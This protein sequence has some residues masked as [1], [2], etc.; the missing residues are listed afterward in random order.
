MSSSETRPSPNERAGVDVFVLN[1]G[2][3]FAWAFVT[4]YFTILNLVIGFVLAYLALYVPRQMWGEVRYFRRIKELVQLVFVFVYELVVSAVAV[5]RLVFKPT[6]DF[7]SGILA[8]PLD[9]D[10]DLE[11]ML[12][13][14]MISLTPGTLSLD[15]SDDKR[16]LYVHAM[17]CD[18]PEAEK[19]TMKRSFERNIREALS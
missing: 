3:A 15:V 18:D 12:F 8:V 19:A 7:R 14:N 2:L 5:V 4:G 17:D 11:I 9:A 16:T 13:A 6:M 1:A 10:N